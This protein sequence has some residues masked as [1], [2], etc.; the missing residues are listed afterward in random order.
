MLQV[1]VIGAGTMGRTHAAA[2]ASM[3]GV[4]LAGIADIR[5]EKAQ[6]LA[7]KY[8]AQAYASFEAT[9]ASLGAT[10]IDVIDVCLPT[11]FIR[12]MLSKPRT[13][14]SMSY[15]RNARQKRSGCTL[16]DQLLPG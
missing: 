1:L 9:V 12:T 16:H 10:R 5:A 3:P 11:R 15:A 6:R 7:D 8:G 13:S 2:Y 4:K 14:A